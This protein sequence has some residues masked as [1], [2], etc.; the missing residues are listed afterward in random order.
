MNPSDFLPVNL[1]SFRFLLF[2]SVAFDFFVGFSSSDSVH[3]ASVRPSPEKLG[4]SLP[5]SPPSSSTVSCI[6]ETTCTS[7][8]PVCTFSKR[9][10]RPET[11]DERVLLPSSRSAKESIAGGFGTRRVHWTPQPAHVHVHTYLASVAND[12]ER[13]RAIADQ[14]ARQGGSRRKASRETLARLPGR[15]SLES[16]RTRLV[17]LSFVAASTSGEDQTR[18]PEIGQPALT[19]GTCALQNSHDRE[20]C[21]RSLRATQESRPSPGAF[22]PPPPCTG[23]QQPP[24]QLPQQQQAPRAAGAGGAAAEQQRAS[25]QRCCAMNQVQRGVVIA[26]TSSN[27]TTVGRPHRPASL[28]IGMTRRC[29]VVGCNRASAAAATTASS[30]SST[31]MSGV[32]TPTSAPA[33]CTSRGF[34]DDCTVN[35]ANGNATPGFE[36]NVNVACSPAGNRGK[37][38]WVSRLGWTSSG[39]RSRNRNSMEPH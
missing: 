25:Q 29:P 13:S 8:E 32:A 39:L 9:T 16:R 6:A 20:T 2:Y 28:D 30:S 12:C 1:I 4:V 36:L 18:R 11:H 21:A 22:P 38:V 31:T 26:T 7:V 23:I 3:S 14:R 33:A 5:A 24:Q 37:P 19:Q 35:N 27:N 34:F 17:V 10:R 15:V